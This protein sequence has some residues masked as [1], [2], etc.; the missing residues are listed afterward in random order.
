M[1][2][3]VPWEPSPSVVA[4]FVAKPHKSSSFFFYS[5]YLCPFLSLHF[6]GTPSNHLDLV[7]MVT[8]RTHLVSVTMAIGPLK[9][10]LMSIALLSIFKVGTLAVF[11]SVVLHGCVE[12]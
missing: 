1:C 4:V 8:V 5:F 7:V 3:P 10:C 9:S 2:G 12:S 11:S 6:A